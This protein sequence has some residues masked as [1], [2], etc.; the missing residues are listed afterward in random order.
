MRTFRGRC[1][2]DARCA[3]RGAELLPRGHRPFACDCTASLVRRP[4]AGCAVGGAL[5]WQGR[6]VAARCR[7]DFAEADRPVSPS[8][9]GGCR[10]RPCA[11]AACTTPLV[12]C[13]HDSA[14]IPDTRHIGA[15]RHRSCCSRRG[16]GRLG[17][18]CQLV[19]R[20]TVT[21]VGPGPV[22]TALTNSPRSLRAV[23][24]VTDRVV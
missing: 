12:A 9:D 13:T 22:P 2:E 4:T 1:S 14:L 3:R 10:A 17:G 23:A 21:R 7:A 15:P 8:M 11:L 16:A 6:R 5:D 20:C 24:A 19:S 18:C